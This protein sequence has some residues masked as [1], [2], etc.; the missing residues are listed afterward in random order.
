MGYVFN[1][2]LYCSVKELQSVDTSD[3]LSKLSSA[4]LLSESNITSTQSDPVKLN[5]V[6]SHV[7]A[8]ILE[9]KI[10]LMKFCRVLMN[11]PVLQK[12]AISMKKKL[13]KFCCELLFI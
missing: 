10:S 9:G 1:C 12:I 3:F 2:Y 13:S 4:N 6:L 11:Y 7:R 8:S 5:D